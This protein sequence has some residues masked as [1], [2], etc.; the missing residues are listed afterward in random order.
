MD[1]ALFSNILR[2]LIDSRGLN[3]KMV[4]DMAETTEPTISRY[5]S[6]Q[7]LP[8]ISIVIRIAKALNISM[9]YLCGLT[10]MPTPKESLGL[11]YHLL[12]RCY[13]RIDDYDKRTLWSLLARNMEK[14]EIE[15]LNNLNA[16]RTGG[17][18]LSY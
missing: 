18:K 10:D 7:T 3:Q 9:D 1:I 14:D 15:Q 8:A 11:E 2:D 4:A 17:I 16:E 5:V 6:G 13:D 12:L